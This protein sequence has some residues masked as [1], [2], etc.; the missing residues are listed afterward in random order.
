MPSEF[1]P[2]RLTLARKRRG[3]TRSALAQAAHLSANIIQ[4]YE[5][6]EKSPSGSTVQSLADILRFPVEFFSAGDVD[7]F[8]ADGVSFRALSSLT[9]AQRDRALAAGGL[10]EQLSQWIEE[11]FT[12]P[13]PDVPSLRGFPPES[14]AE[15]L[16]AEW[17]LGERPIA[18]MLH[19]LEARGVRVFSLPTDC[20][21]IDAFSVWRDDI[22]FVFLTTTKSGER[23]RFDAAHEL[24]HL[25]L[26]QRGGPTGREAE[27]E[28]DRFASAFLMPRASVIASAPRSTTL[29]Y[30]IKLKENWMVSVAALVHRLKSLNLITEWHYRT[31]CIEL[32]QKGYRTNEPGQRIQRESSQLLSKVFATLRNEGVSRATV[33]RELDILG[34][35]LESVIF[36]M[37]IT[38][39]PGGRRNDPTS[40]RVPSTNR[41]QVVPND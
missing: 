35:E 18:N 38:S 22:P 17:R 14:A 19:L 36:G 1:C 4:A 30:L 13:A 9:A 34:E 27:S 15:A 16:R 6:C 39:V 29:S 10:A 31:L 23:G 5:R 41:L 37:V 12:T 2:S 11:R 20:S 8:R 25:T 33:A 7:E 32:S 26:H 28:A 3:M 21:R 24:G 40:A